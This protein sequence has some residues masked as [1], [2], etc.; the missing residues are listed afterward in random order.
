M[1]NDQN[2][3][4]LQQFQ[5]KVRQGLKHIQ[6]INNK[7]INTEVSNCHQ[8]FQENLLKWIYRRCL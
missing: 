4:Q 5:N 7:I 1:I 3:T 8:I 6:K 2:K